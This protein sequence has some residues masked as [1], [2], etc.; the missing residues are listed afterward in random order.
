VDEKV[1]EEI[2]FHQEVIGRDTNSP[3]HLIREKEMEISGRVLAAKNEAERIVNDARHQ[4]GDLLRSSEAEAEKLAKETEATVLAEA[5]VQASRLR[6]GIGGEAQ[7]LETAIAGRRAA[8][9]A[10]IIRIVTT[11]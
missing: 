8:A 2:G 6:E 1:L 9:V 7:E 4:A 10:E 3:L 11:V 5:E